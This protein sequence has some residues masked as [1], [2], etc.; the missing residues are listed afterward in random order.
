MKKFLLITTL[1]LWLVIIGIACSTDKVNPKMDKT[2]SRNQVTA[3]DILGNPDYLAISYGGYRKNTR[4][5][6][7]SLQELKE[8]L[9]ILSAMNIKLLRTYNT[10]YAQAAN[11][12]QAIQDLKEEDE[13]FEM[14]AMLGEWIGYKDASTANPD[15]EGENTQENE[16]EIE[17][18]MELANQHRDFVKI[19]AVG[20]EA[21]VNWAASY[22][23]KPDIILKYVQKL[24]N[25][26]RE[27]RLP[28][29]LW[30]NSSDNFASW[31]GGGDEYHTEDLTELIKAQDFISLHTNPMHDPHYNPEFWVVE[32]QF[33]DLGKGAKIETA[34]LSAK[35][36]ALSKFNTVKTYVESLG[37]TKPLHIGETGSASFSKRHFSPEGSKAS[38]EYKEALYHD[39]MREWSNPKGVSCFYF[40][41]FDE[42]WKD[43]ENPGGSENHFGLFTV[44]GKAKYVLWD[45]VDQG[46]FD[47]PTRNGNAIVKT[48]NGSKDALLREVAIP[49]IKKEVT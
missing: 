30:I 19:I 36:Y 15:H 37:I 3:K 1:P 11:V 4:E 2:K 35:N 7:A 6:Q 10:H 41:A 44:E 16:E 46:V 23:A 47:G 9:K 25:L 49:P 22:Y 14:Y 17:R 31:E 12:L 28:K 27:G 18:A 34:M 8:D 5:V 29:G 42:E 20:S 40:E 48:Y 39:Y 43:A 33:S 45:V 38:D 21:K 13:N 26:K 32:S 24:Q